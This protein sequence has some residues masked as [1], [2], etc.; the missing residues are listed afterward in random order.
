[1]DARGRRQNGYLRLP[2][3][4]NMCLDADLVVL[5]ACQTALGKEI[6]GEGLVGLT[7]AFI[8]AGA[9]AL[10]A[11]HWSVDSAATVKLITSAVRAITGAQDVTSA[12]QISAALK[13]RTRGSPCSGSA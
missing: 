10:L 9:R 11:S 13:R 2:D 6:K 8:Y 7:R 3:I 4:Y 5:S 12:G 1:M